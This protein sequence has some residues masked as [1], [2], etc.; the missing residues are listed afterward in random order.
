MIKKKKSHKNIVLGDI[1]K[2]KVVNEKF[3]PIQETNPLIYEISYN[4]KYNSVENM[5]TEELEIILP[6]VNSFKNE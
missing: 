1:V 2:I 5:L 3:E 4:K 6:G